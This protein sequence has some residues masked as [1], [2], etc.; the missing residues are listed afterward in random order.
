MEISIVNI[1][2]MIEGKNKKYECFHNP[3]AF[4]LGRSPL[5]LI[6]VNFLILSDKARSI[7]KKIK[8]PVKITLLLEI[9]RV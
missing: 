8:I 5:I 7:V 2:K 9:I 6:P 3:S 4:S 1:K